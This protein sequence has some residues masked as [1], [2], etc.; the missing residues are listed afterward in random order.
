MPTTDRCKKNMT[1]VKL[2]S[3]FQIWRDDTQIAHALV[4][5]YLLHTTTKLTTQLENNNFASNNNFTRI[6]HYN[7]HATENFSTHRG[8]PISI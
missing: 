6:S 4:F 2:H 8:V 1:R 7:V 5:L 3:I